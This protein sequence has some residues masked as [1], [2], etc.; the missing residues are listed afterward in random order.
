MCIR[1]SNYGIYAG[2]KFTPAIELKGI[3]YFQNLGDNMPVMDDSQKA[4]K[5]VL[6]VKQE[7]LK[8][9]S[10]WLQSVSYT[11]LDV[12]KRQVAV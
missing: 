6:D 9:T 7:A 11:H 2:F 3:Y 4:W 12:Y 1:D 8:F 10:L 5:A